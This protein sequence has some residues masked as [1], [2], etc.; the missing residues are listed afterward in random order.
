MEAGTV[1][2][3]AP[4]VGVALS[5]RLLRLT[6]DSRLVALTREGRT[7]AFE[8]AYDRH[9]RA[10]LSFCRH[11]LG[12]LEEAQ[13]AVQ[14]TFL[15]AYNS[16][17]GSDKP[18]HLRAWLFTIARNRCYSILRSRREQPSGDLSEALTEG[19]ATQVQ[20]RQDL[21]DL[22]VDLQGLPDEQRAA[23]VLAE[24]DSLSHQE[25]GDVLGVSRDKVK[26]LVFQA[27]ES[28]MASRTARETDCTEI[29]E[30][31]ATLRGGSLRR[32]NLRRHLREC[33]AC[34]EFRKHVERQ[35]RQ[36]AILLPVGPSIA[37]KEM[38]FAGTVAGG[39]AAGTVAGGGLVATSALKGG[40]FKFVIGAVA[41]GIGTASTIAVTDGVHLQGNGPSRAHHHLLASRPGPGRAKRNHASG[42]ATVIHRHHASST[43]I[44]APAILA[45]STTHRATTRYVVDHRLA[46][47]GH[48]AKHGHTADH[49]GARLVENV[50]KRHH[51]HASA[52]SRHHRQAVALVADVRGTKRHQRGHKA[53]YARHARHRWRVWHHARTKTWRASQARSAARVHHFGRQPAHRAHVRAALAR[54]HHRAA[55]IHH[56]AARIYHAWAH[57][58]V[59]L[60]RALDLHLVHITLHL[61]H[62]QAR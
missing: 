61:R 2:R 14:H 49:R 59:R 28:L 5:P 37:V 32:G 4:G 42:H 20:R 8:V 18:I 52:H 45:A 12:D 30:Q 31:L 27:R 58:A 10:I 50:G 19:L 22:M 13:D 23:L 43:P 46:H 21:R 11:M 51:R 41:A 26:A 56:W 17:I 54:V 9:H 44:G 15:A 55:Q 39:A 57:R 53:R 35:R 1:P 3:G 16:L 7:A 36:L 33:A 62:H 48:L 38:V 24:L 29:R 6:S 34:R 40:A 47:H 25:I 60:H